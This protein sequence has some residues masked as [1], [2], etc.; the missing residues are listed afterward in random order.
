MTLRLTI[1]TL[2]PSKKTCVGVLLSLVTLQ[3]QVGAEGP[4]C[5]FLLRVLGRCMQAPPGGLLQRK[6]LVS[7]PGHRHISHGG[8]SGAP[9]FSTP[10][11]P[12][13]PG[14]S[15]E[16]FPAQLPAAAAPLCGQFLN[17]ACGGGGAL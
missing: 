9:L 4:G 3:G 6:P 5:F 17:A 2:W 11:A 10:P 1:L 7:G 13:S 16:G 12:P 8:F 14:G 15:A